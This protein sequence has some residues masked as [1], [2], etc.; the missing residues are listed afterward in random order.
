MN[1]MELLADL[2]RRQYRQGPGCDSKTR[3]ALELA[4]LSGDRPLRV[5]DIGCGT[6]AS[7]RALGQALRGEITAVDFLPEFLAELSE[8]IETAELSAQISTCCA[9]MASLPFGEQEL[10]LI[11]SEGAVY[12][13]GFENGIRCWRT[14]LKHGGLLVVSEITWLTQQ[15]PSEIEDFWTRHYPEIDT[16][17][18]K[19]RVLEQQGYHPVG[20]F[21]L[22]QYCWRDNYYLPLEAS[23]EDFLAR[24]RNSE[25]AAAVVK[26]HR[27]EQALYEKYCDQYSYGFYIARKAD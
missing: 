13:I 17:A 6:G 18:G 9:D 21:T 8:R 25:A 24:H 12:N 10:D 20:Y 15:R 2:H 5:A 27:Q 23:F 26:E 22:P 4:A 11:W 19:F 3:L 7:T 16:A 1:E 14:H